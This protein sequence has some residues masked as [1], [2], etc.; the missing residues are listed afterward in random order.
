GE[1]GR[2]IIG[3]A[4]GE[5]GG[6]PLA[7]LVDGDG[8][9]TLNGTIEHSGL[10][11]FMK[12]DWYRALDNGRINVKLENVRHSPHGVYNSEATT[13]SLVLSGN[14]DEMHL[15]GDI[16][17]VSGRYMQEFDLTAGFLSARRVEEEE[18]PFWDGDPF[19]SAL[20]LHLT[21]RTRGLF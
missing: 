1:G 18:K 19:L 12:S 4:L 13:P 20:Q 21:M 5:Q 17:V 2:I 3:K 14:R 6:E 11:G 16:E 10:G 15:T 9:L 8:K 7:G